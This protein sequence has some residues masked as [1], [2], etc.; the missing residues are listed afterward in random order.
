LIHRRD[1]VFSPIYLFE[2]C[3]C[4]VS[5]DTSYNRNTS[6]ALSELNKSSKIKKNLHKKARILLTGEKNS[7]FAKAFDL[8]RG[9]ARVKK[10][11][12]KEEALCIITFIIFFR[13]SFFLF[14][15]ILCKFCNSCHTR[16]ISAQ[17]LLLYVIL[18]TN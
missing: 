7:N 13:F 18:K 17:F 3:C 6:P 8:M 4:E 2:I 15:T 5:P 1:R 14:Q 10:R 11:A 12:N 9:A 16:T